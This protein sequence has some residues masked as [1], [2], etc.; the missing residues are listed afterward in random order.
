MLDTLRSLY[1]RVALRLRGARVGSGL[2]VGGPLRILCRDGASLKGLTIGDRVTFTGT[3]HLRMRRQGR[4]TIGDGVS[5]GTEVWLVAANDTELRIGR[6]T[7]IGSYC[8]LNGGHGVRIGEKCW[9]AAF[10]YVNTSDHRIA[11]DRPIQEQGYVGAPVAIG[12]DS[13]IGGHAFISKGVTA[14]T[15]AVI[16]AGSVVTR[17]V[18]PYAVVVGNPARL[19][20][21][22]E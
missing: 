5:L 6:D 2:R 19:L 3:T 16:G 21:Y 20:R 12:D 22:R 4:V 18:P 15:G 8:I 10:V 17:D 1:W 9:F 7:I 13:W 14:G 11:R